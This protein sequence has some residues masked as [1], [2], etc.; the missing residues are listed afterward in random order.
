MSSVV[1]KFGEV[2]SSIVPMQSGMKFVVSRTLDGMPEDIKE[3]LPEVGSSGFVVPHFESKAVIE[4]SAHLMFHAKQHKAATF[5]MHTVACAELLKSWPRVCQALL[6][7]FSFA[8]S[9][10]LIERKH[11]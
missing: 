1:D 4:V 10:C 7:C 2:G 6:S 8:P 5:S 11:V 3:A 9:R